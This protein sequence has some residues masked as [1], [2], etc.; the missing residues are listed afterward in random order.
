MRVATVDGLVTLFYDGSKPLWNQELYSE[1]Y[2]QYKRRY[3]EIERWEEW[4]LSIECKEYWRERLSWQQVIVV[5]GVTEIPRETFLYCVNVKKVIF[6]N[7]VIRI[8]NRAFHFCF[9]LVYIKL[10]INLEYIG[11]D[12]F[13]SCDLSSVFLPPRCRE[14]GRYAFDCNTNLAIVHVPQNVE[15]GPRVFGNTKLIDDSSFAD[16]EDDYGD[17][18]FADEE[19]VQEW[20][21]NINNDDKYALHRA[22]CSFSPSKQDI[23]TILEEIGIGA[24][25]VENGAGIT[26]SQYLKENPYADIDE[27]D[28]IRDYTLKMMGE[29]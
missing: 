3:G 9:D 14:V 23:F 15:L 16:E 26:P 18:I 29:L 13:G 19:A 25:S 6:A 2:P 4:N 10:S 27:M 24:F 21:K 8:E 17:Y 28:I 22:C 5:D 11:E 1:W 20:I 7:T 12:V